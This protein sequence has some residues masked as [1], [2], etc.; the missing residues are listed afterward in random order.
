MPSRSTILSNY[1]VVRSCDPAF[2]RDR[3]FKVYGANSFDVRKPHGFAMNADH[4]QIGGVGLS[5]VE[6]TGE[7]SVGFGEVSFVRQCFS[8]EVLLATPRAGNP[9]KSCRDHGVRSFPHTSR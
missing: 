5:Y 6:Y 9:G 1:P 7:V 2:A 3:L 4:V 8:I